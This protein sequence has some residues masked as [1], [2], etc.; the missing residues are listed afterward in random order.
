MWVPEFEHHRER[1]I[2]RR[3]QRRSQFD[4]NRSLSRGQCRLKLMRCVAEVMDAI[5]LEPLPVG[6]FRYALAFL[7]HPFRVCARLDRSLDLRCR[8][9]Q[10]VK[11][12][13]NLASPFQTSRQIDRT[14]KSAGR[15]GSM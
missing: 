6:L 8:Y 4:S 13:Q 15:R 10:L 14:M 3:Q 2:Q 5:E 9:H 1:A 11:R 7:Y 12:N